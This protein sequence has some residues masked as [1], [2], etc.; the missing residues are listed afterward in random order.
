[1]RRLY[2]SFFTYKL[3]DRQGSKE[4]KRQTYRQAGG[5]KETEDAKEAHIYIYIYIYIHI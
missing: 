1:M 3:T 2:L 4:A 5:Q